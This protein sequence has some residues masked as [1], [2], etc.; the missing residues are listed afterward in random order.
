[1]DD[2]GESITPIERQRLLHRQRMRIRTVAV[3]FAAAVSSAHRDL[4][5]GAAE[6]DA[7]IETW[8]AWSLEVLARYRSEIED[9]ADDADPAAADELAGLREAV[10]EAI[11]RVRQA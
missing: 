3:S 6:R 7:L 8:R 11:E 5:V 9:L 10:G 1:M 4:D 2:M